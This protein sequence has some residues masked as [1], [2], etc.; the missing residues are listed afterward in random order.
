PASIYARSFKEAQS[1]IQ[2]MLIVVILPLAVIASVPTIQLNLA[3]AIIPVVNVGLASRE[4][5]A[6][7]IDFGLLAVV[8]L[9]LLAFAGIGIALC[10]RWFGQE[11]NILRR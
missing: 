7:T 1:L 8:F 3:T 2:P 4:V 5:I 9:S 10:V 6:G 11:G